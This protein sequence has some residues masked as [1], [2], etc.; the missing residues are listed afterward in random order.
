MISV[1]EAG[2]LPSTPRPICDSNASMISA[3]KPFG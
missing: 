1:P 2:T 3:G